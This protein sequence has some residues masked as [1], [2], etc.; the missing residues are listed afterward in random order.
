MGLLDIKN[1]SVHYK[2]LRGVVRAVEDVSL[3]IDRGR[4][5]AIVGETGS[6]KT[7]IGLT[8]LRI[9]PP[10]AI[11]KSGEVLYLGRDLLRLGNEEMRRLRSKEISII[12]QEPKI[13]LNP[14]MK[15]GEQIA[16]V[17]M[18]HEGLS[19]K[20]AL[21]LAREMLRKTGI[22][23]PDRVMN[24]YPHELSGGMA[25]RVVI[26]IAMI[27]K[28]KLLVADEPTSALDVS[29]QAQVLDLITELVRETGTSVIFITHDLS[30]AAE[31]AD[32][33]AVMYYGKIVERGNIY[34]IFKS[35]KHPYTR[36]L[37]SAIPRVGFRG[38]LHGLDEVAESVL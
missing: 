4:V 12:F 19:K 15:I 37:L 3:E 9:L 30:L 23:D 20:E 27:L 34:D 33:V 10:N 5:L 16:E 6:G 24:S 36:A 1:L 11:I 26:S 31:I 29:I 17:P 8:V 25:Q 13:T 38:R 28:P 14:I 2:T 22:P 7:T 32:D 21:Q 18:E 35:P